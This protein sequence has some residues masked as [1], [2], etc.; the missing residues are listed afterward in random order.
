MA[1]SQAPKEKKSLPF[2]KVM[3]QKGQEYVPLALIEEGQDGE[4]DD[5]SI[6]GPEHA[7]SSHERT[8]KQGKILKVLMLALVCFVSLRSY[9]SKVDQA[10]VSSVETTLD[11][12]RFEAAAATLEIMKRDTQKAASKSY[13]VDI[14][15]LADVVDKALDT[16]GFRGVFLELFETYSFTAATMAAAA[17]MGIKHLTMVV[18]HEVGQRPESIYSG[19]P[20]DRWVNETDVCTGCLPGLHH[21]VGAIA[22]DKFLRDGSLLLDA[23]TGERLYT[24]RDIIKELQRM[25]ELERP[26]MVPFHSQHGFIWYYVPYTT[27]SLL[28]VFPTDLAFEICGDLLSEEKNA[29][30][31]D[32]KMSAVAGVDIVRECRHGFGHAVYYILAMRQ[33][34]RSDEFS[35]RT[36]LRT[37][38]G[39]VLKD[40]YLCQANRICGGAPNRKTA[41]LCTYGFRHAY[42]EV[43]NGP[44]MSIHSKDVMDNHCE[45]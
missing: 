25:M 31:H 11:Q 20:S 33:A 32:I 5:V 29:T 19:I 12:L 41:H 9:Q 26:D 38:G 36:Q 18:E 4:L 16:V 45:N 13:F 43:S 7:I 15:E 2:C 3:R 10:S 40:E 30:F 8:D 42:Y 21:W 17:A 28:D 1:T 22:A 27:P 14:G 24:A 23:S 35:A 37:R 6:S 39:F 44:Y 34:G